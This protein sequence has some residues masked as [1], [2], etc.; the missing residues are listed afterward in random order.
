VKW[1]LALMALAACSP[2]PVIGTWRGQD[3][4]TITFAADGTVDVPI[5]TDG[6]CPATP[7]CTS[8]WR[9]DGGTLIFEAASVARRSP[10]GTSD[11]FVDDP[12]AC[13]C[14]KER[15]VL[16][17]RGD[18]LLVTGTDERATRVR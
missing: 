15:V 5:T 1:A 14:R 7:S 18:E 10:G 11:L 6:R 2:D 9:R 16:E 8:T 3:G 12:A 13:D 4:R 17:L